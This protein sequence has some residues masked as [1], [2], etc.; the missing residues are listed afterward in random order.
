MRYPTLLGALL[1]LG[2]LAA[3][4]QSQL[5][6]RVLDRQTRQPVPYASVVV[7]GTTQGTTSNADGEFVLRVN[8]LPVKVLAFSLG[9]GRDSATVAQ[10]G[11]ALTLALAPAPVALPA[12]EG[13]SYAAELLARAYRELQRT[14]AYPQYGQ[15]FYRQVTRLGDDPTEVQEMVWDVKATS[16]GLAGFSYAQGR[17]AAKKALVHF[18]NFPN[19]SLDASFFAPGVDSA[20]YKAVVSPN[21]A[22]DYTLRL[23]GLTQSGSHPVAE[24]AFASKADARQGSVYI[25]TDTYQVLHFVVQMPATTTSNNPL[26]RFREPTIT[27]EFDLAPQPEAA[28]LNY[29]KI[30]YNGYIVRPLRAD[31]NMQVNSFTYFYNPQSTPT[32]AAYSN[33]SAPLDLATIKQKPYDAAFWR[34]NPVVKR[35]PLE[36]EVLRSFENQKAFGTMLTK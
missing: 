24:V 12:V 33:A 31:M 29:L 28:R 14:A 6:G 13:S 5:S 4:A 15:A 17:Y 19:Y 32:A 25:D 16:A 18:R 11:P 23:K 27:L 36:E 35:T 34:D 20:A 1:S 30:T 10:A 8:Q 22:R 21:A 2:P 7:A 26:F 9:Y 3:Q